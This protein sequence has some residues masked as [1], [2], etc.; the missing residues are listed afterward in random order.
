MN[1][2]DHEQDER[3]RELEGRARLT[4]VLFDDHYE[5]LC[6]H[7]DI[8]KVAPLSEKSY[9][10]RGSTALLDAVGKSV[11][12][13]RGWIDGAHPDERPDNVVVLVMTDGYENS[14]KEYTGKQIRDLV[15]ETQANGWEYVFL[16]ADIDAFGV[17]AD[18]AMAQ[19]SSSRVPKSSLGIQEAYRKM[20]RAVT[21]LRSTGSKGDVDADLDAD[22]QI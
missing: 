11:N 12:G 4:L 18:L 13:A 22:D 16:G 5:V 14:S 9:F 3:Q 10:V 1:R 15:A 17:T 6:K 20:N 8:E 19:G 2:S 21:N 7:T